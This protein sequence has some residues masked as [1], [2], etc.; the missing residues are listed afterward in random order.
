MLELQAFQVAPWEYAPTWQ[1]ENI[2]QYG[3]LRVWA[4][5]VR[6]IESVELSLSLSEDHK[7]PLDMP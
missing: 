7:S 1:V 3:A 6:R 2:R 5:M 4:N